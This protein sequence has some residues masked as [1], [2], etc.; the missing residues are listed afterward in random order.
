[1]DEHKPEESPFR[2]YLRAYLRV[3]P[4][5]VAVHRAV[6]AGY[7]AQIPVEHPLLD[8][9]CGFGEFGSI[10]FEEPADV[11]ID[12]SRGDLRV[13]SRK[14]VYRLLSQAD[15]RSLPFANES[16]AGVISI[17]TLEHIPSV[18]D[19]VREA[20][21]VLR[22]GGAFLFTLPSDSFSRMLAVP[23]MLS[24]LRAAPLGRAYARALNSRLAHVN[25]W[26]PEQWRACIEGAGFETERCQEIVSPR[27]TMVY[28][29]GLAF[30]MPERFWRILTGHRLT[31]PARVV[32]FLESR[33]AG[34]VEAHS[35]D[36]SNLFVVARKPT[37]DRV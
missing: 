7:L 6:E 15:G 16:F 34:L 4:L 22:P 37:T 36:G 31:K 1:M 33:F 8:L 24:A 30:A 11:G 35:S 32:S 2:R 13:A 23:R 20:F 19:V 9:G 18:E 3:A 5:S 28:D 29:L 12:L 14:G 25:L 27:V 17:S 21:R 26:S 10:F